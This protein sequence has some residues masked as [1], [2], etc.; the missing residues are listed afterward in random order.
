MKKDIVISQWE[1]GPFPD[2]NSQFSGSLKDKK[3][4]NFQGSQ[5]TNTKILYYNN[6]EVEQGEDLENCNISSSTDM[7]STLEDKQVDN[8]TE[9][10]KETN[11][12][13]HVRFA[14]YNEYK[15]IGLTDTSMLSTDSHA[16]NYGDKAWSEQSASSESSDVES[17]PKTS[18]ILENIPRPN[19]LSYN[20]S[21]M[22]YP[23]K[24]VLPPSLQ[25]RNL[26]TYEDST[27]HST[28][29]EH[30]VLN[31]SEGT[32]YDEDNTISELQEAV[33][34]TMESY[35]DKVKEFS[36]LDITPTNDNPV[37]GEKTTEDG[38]IFK[39]ELLKTRLLELE[40]EIEIF[41]RE[42]TTLAGV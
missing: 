10:P 21:S 40:R 36:L 7:D 20:R 41:R 3:I 18:N 22:K 5:Q 8:Y 24:P 29:D 38:T 23:S 16:D 11:G 19:Q 28:D 25:P 33:R 32:Y 42:N 17:L 9:D 31:D 2:D 34:K 14:E 6:N 37:Q 35:N 30:S 13:M 1:S 39:S 26:Q 12:S 15:T 4:A 27:D